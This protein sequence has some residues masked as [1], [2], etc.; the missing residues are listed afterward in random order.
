V[1]I[2]ALFMSMSPPVP[3][4]IPIGKRMLRYARIFCL[5][6]ETP[7]SRPPVRPCLECRLGPRYPYTLCN[8]NGSLKE[9]FAGF[10]HV[11]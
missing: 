4:R 1:C 8:T 9:P 10:E 11:L 5:T 6:R 7:S 3:T 2:E